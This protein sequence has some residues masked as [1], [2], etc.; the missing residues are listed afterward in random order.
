MST[1]TVTAN[2]LNSLLTVLKK[3][4]KGGYMPARP[5]DAF[6]LW[7]DFE[8]NQPGNLVLDLDSALFNELLKEIELKGR[9]VADIGCGTG[10][11]WPKLLKAKPAAVTGFDVSAGRLKR[12]EQKFPKAQTNQVIDNLFADIASETYDVIVSN[13]TIAHI[14]YMEEALTNWCR[15]LK[16]ESDIIITDFHPDTLA[17][18]GRHTFRY[19][20]HGIAVQSFVHD[21]NDI[22]AILLKNG[23]TIVNKLELKIDKTVKRYYEAKDALSEYEKFKDS[24]VVYGIHLKRGGGY[25]IT[26][27]DDPK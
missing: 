8:D 2:P 7:V 22:A 15:I 23:F 9:Q 6:D 5:D 14:Q 27:T 20:A 17:T 24:P 13:L 4:F 19:N 12:L 18:G 26:L 11:H 16:P 3:A 25:N 10:R 21:I 1:A